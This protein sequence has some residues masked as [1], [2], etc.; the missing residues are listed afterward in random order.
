MNGKSIN[1]KFNLTVALAVAFFLCFGTGAASS[2]LQSP[3]QQDL[4]QAVMLKVQART[5]AQLAEVIRLCESALK[6]GLEPKDAE[7]AKQL[8][9]GTRIQ[10]GLQ[11]AREILPLIPTNHP[12]F[13][14][15][16][17]IAVTDLSKGLEH[18]PGIAVAWLALARLE[19]LPGGSE[20]NARRAVD[21]AVA[22]AGDNSSLRAEAL[23]V[24]AALERDSARRLEDL[25]AAI[26]AKPDD[27]VPYRLRGALLAD[28]GRVDEALADLNQA[29]QL[30][31]D[32]A[33]TWQVKGMIL[34]KAQ[35]YEEALACFEKVRELAPSA[36]APLLEKARILGLQTKFEEALQ[37]LNEVVESDP[38]NIAA[39]LLR[40]SVMAELKR[41]A[42]ALQDVDRA[43]SL[44]PNL[45]LALRLRVSLLV[46]LEK[47]GEAARTLARLREL[48]PE[49]ANLLLQQGILEAGL[50]RPRKAIALLTQYL[51]THPEDSLALIARGNSFISIGKHAEALADF[52]KALPL[53]GHDATFLNNFAW[54]LCT[55]PDDHLRDG[56]RALELAQKACELL[57][58]KA[59]FALS[60][61]AAAYAELG[62]FQKAMEWV[63]KAVELAEGEEKEHIQKELE[64]YR[65]GKPFRERQ[66]KPDAPEE[67]LPTN[68]SDE[69]V[70]LNSS[71]PE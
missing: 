66:E 31:P 37:R 68:S 3:G 50:G 11:L 62:D 27:P 7:F 29:L 69:I 61:L 47:L 1:Q 67:E 12:D 52:E 53:A 9:A 40:A 23:L 34:A 24:R 39:L 10:R 64:C 6:K 13:A 70:E 65:Q 71:P 57:E 60:T 58:F 18:D 2:A 22:H 35:R 26:E 41:D 25:T 45:S 28:L 59:A 17:E 49:D 46:R 36:T 20:P 8:L 21:Q 32:D 55:S 63:Q 5:F 15:L 16:R 43:L 33:L 38:E 30:E 19:L 44:D 14:K 4:D 54:I 48:E 42:E 56:R 51:E